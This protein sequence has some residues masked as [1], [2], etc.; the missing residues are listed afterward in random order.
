MTEKKDRKGHWNKKR[1]KIF[2]RNSQTCFNS[3]FVWKGIPLD[4]IPTT[5]KP[6]IKIDFYEKIW[7]HD[8]EWHKLQ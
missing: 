3:F 6:T 7:I 8:V 1:R 4:G 2:S 5:L